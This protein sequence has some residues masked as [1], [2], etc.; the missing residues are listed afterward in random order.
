MPL[1]IELNSLQQENESLRHQLEV[2]R[3]WMRREVDQAVHA[4]SK[5]KV[6]KMTEVD[7]EGFLR[8][9]QE[10]IISKRIGDYFGDLLLLN[11]PKE[12]IEHLINAEINFYNLG[13]NPTLDG[14]SV[15]SSYHKIFDILTEHMIV[16]QFRKYTLKKGAPILRVNDPMEKALHLVITKKHILSLGRL[17]GLLQSIRTGAPLYDFGKSFAEYLDKYPSLR[18]LLI[19]DTFFALFQKVINSEIFGA[20]RH[21]GS[22]SIGDTKNART[23]ILGDFT[24]K[25]SLLYM[26]L[27][28]QA[29]MY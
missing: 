21:Q 4:I 9:N 17:Y 15:V 29:V 10:A 18:D 6:T 28:S 2:C 16:H 20:K 26:I 25:E 27:E 14:F 1:Q 22:I 23:W 8:E 24:D 5:R 19:S 11:A 7:R 3:I 12:M 13:K